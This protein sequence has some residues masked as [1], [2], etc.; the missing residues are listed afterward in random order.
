MYAIPTT[1]VSVLRG[2]QVDEFGDPADTD[3]V[4]VSGVPASLIEQIRTSATPDSATPRVVRYTVGRV[5]ADTDI[6]EDDRVLDEAS[7]EVYIIQAVSRLGN[8]VLRADLRLDL[9]RTT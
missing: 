9:K 1:T 6:R 5:G 4:V 2:T 8:P 7:G 3:T